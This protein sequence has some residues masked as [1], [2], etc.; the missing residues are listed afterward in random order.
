MLQCHKVLF[1]FSTFP[2]EETKNLQARS[3]KMKEN[4]THNK[5]TKPEDKAES[6]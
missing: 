4:T 6:D 1:H 5:E 2:F 3:H